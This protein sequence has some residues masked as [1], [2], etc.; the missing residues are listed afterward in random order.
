[1]IYIIDNNEPPADHSLYFVEVS[2]HEREIFGDVLEP[3]LLIC[4]WFSN[5]FIAGIADS[6]RWLKRPIEAESLGE[7][8]NLLRLIE[9]SDDFQTIKRNPKL[10]PLSNEV[11]EYLIESHIKWFPKDKDRLQ[12]NYVNMHWDEVRRIFKGDSE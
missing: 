5:P 8:L 11:I 9:I 1:M 10:P 12:P 3:M 6:I 4:R 2:E 7:S